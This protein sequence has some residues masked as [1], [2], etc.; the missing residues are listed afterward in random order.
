MGRDGEER[1]GEEDSVQE[2]C[3]GI[4]ILSVCWGIGLLGDTPPLFL[5]RDCSVYSDIGLVYTGQVP[6]QDPFDSGVRC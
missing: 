3:K 4:L 5:G 1:G 6:G 2:W